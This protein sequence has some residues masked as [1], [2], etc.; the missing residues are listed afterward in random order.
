MGSILTI[1]SSKGGAGKT[2]LAQLLAV[3]LAQRGYRLTVLDTDLNGSFGEWH[4]NAYEG[5]TFKLIS[6]TRHVE[7]I[8]TAQAEA[9][10]ADVVVVDTAGFGNLTTASA[11]AVADFALIPTM[12]DRGSVREAIRTA[13]QVESLGKAARR[14]I[15]FRVVGS[16]W[17]EGG[18]SEAVAVETLAAES[19]PFMTQFL[20]LMAAF[21][22]ASHTGRLPVTGKVGYAA[23]LLI[24]ELVALGAV[25]AA[26]GEREDA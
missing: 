4:A 10:L 6:E 18:L 26:P 3:N 7:L 11:L 2:T 8:D 1:A 23:D 16:A 5:P 15:P 22:N 24:D 21:K 14:P 9:E 17:R 25:P 12:A 13:R 19:L 20:P